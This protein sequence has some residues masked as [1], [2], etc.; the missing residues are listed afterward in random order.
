MKEI[1][2]L[3][4]ALKKKSFK[5]KQATFNH[6]YD[7]FCIAKNLYGWERVARFINSE[8]GDNLATSAYKSMYKR[9]KKSHEK[10]NN[11]SE[12][13]AKNS[14]LTQATKAQAI[15]GFFSQREKERKPEHDA[16]ATVAKFEEK[17]S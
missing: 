5:S 7:N 8:T 10:I 11:E 4:E 6:Y 12:V 15:K 16:S 9:A 13:V 14:L 17:Y 3:C 1:E 2:E